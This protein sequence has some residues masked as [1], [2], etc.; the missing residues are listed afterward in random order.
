M[1]K[2]ADYLNHQ[3]NYAALNMLCDSLLTM[4]SVPD[5]IYS[6][7][8]ISLYMLGNNKESIEFLNIA[9]SRNPKNENNFYWRANAQMKLGN[10]NAAIADHTSALLIDPN[11]AFALNNRGE[12]YK[13]QERYD[14][15][16]A[17]LKKAIELDSSILVAYNNVGTVYSALN[18]NDSALYYYDFAINIQETDYL[19]FDRALLKMKTAK[20]DE[21]LLDFNAAE[22]LNKTDPLIYLYRGHCHSYLKNDELMCS[23]YEKA[24]N[25]GSSE[26]KEALIEVCSGGSNVL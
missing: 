4:D 2:R 12:I 24:A 22:R 8:G 3:N 1:L 6:Y 10:K 20:Y 18:K 11:F 26:A 19:Y 13:Q 15:A 23:D 9:I 16:L 17:D 21:A 5:Q 25:L 14:L 7:K